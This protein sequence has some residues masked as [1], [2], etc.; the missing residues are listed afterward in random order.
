MSIQL[1]VVLILQ[2]KINKP[3]YMNC[4]LLTTIRLKGGRGEGSVTHGQDGPRFKS[5]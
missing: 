4:K 1:N 3:K 5:R 2:L